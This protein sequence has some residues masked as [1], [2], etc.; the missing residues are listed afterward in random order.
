MPQIMNVTIEVRLS[1]D[2]KVF[3]ES[4]LK[5]LRSSLDDDM[6]EDNMEMLKRIVKWKERKRMKFKDGSM[7]VDLLSASAILHVYR[8]VRHSNKLKMMKLMNSTKS[9]F[10]EL[11]RFAIRK[12]N[13]E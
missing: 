1:A 6:V 13:M 7:K 10:S 2:T 5:T 3:L 4:C 9:D 11:A 12:V 8:K